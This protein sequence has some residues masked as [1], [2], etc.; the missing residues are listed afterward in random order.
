MADKI[1]IA[2]RVDT[3]FAGGVHEDEFEIDSSEWNSMSEDQQAEYLAKEAEQYLFER[4][5]AYAYVVDNENKE[6]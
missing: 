3:G 4:C 5:E 1:T 2:L 6:K